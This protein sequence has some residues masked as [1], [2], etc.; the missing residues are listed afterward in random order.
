MRFTEE[1]YSGNLELQQANLGHPFVLGIGDGSLSLD[2]FKHFVRQD[3]LYLIEY[4]KV[5][6]L[7]VVKSPSLDSMG[8]FASLLNET[9]NVEMALH[10]S[11]C[12]RLGISYEELEGT[13]PT[14][15]TRA[16]TDFLLQTG[17]HG[18]FGELASALLPCMW[19]Y[20]EIG[21]D[22]LKKGKPDNQPFFGEW[23]DMYSGDEFQ[24]LADWMRNLVDGLGVE[25][26]LD[27]EV[28][29]NSAY[30]TSLRYEYGFWDM[31]WKLEGTVE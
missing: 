2:K 5:L 13:R 4:S 3:Y 25:A 14:P 20:C 30:Q 17:F 15:T 23:I 18:S 1:L 22:L 11:Y 7:A 19:G 10:R 6:A 27:E 29:M 31:A 28:R 26:N 9:L 24:E 21:L 8:R 16:Y 12:L